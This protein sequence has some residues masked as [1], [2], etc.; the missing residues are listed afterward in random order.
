MK[1]IP[2]WILEDPETEFGQDGQGVIED[3]GL[4]GFIVRPCL[5]TTKHINLNGQTLFGGLKVSDQK[6]HFIS[7]R[8]GLE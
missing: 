7:A 1:I 6:G 5:V 4:D 8:S 2:G 3:V